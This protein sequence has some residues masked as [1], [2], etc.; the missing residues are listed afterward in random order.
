MECL[1][2]KTSRFLDR[3]SLLRRVAP[4]QSVHLDLGTGDGRYVLDRARRDPGSFVIGIDACRENLRR[5]SRRAP[6]NT[7]FIIANLLSPP[8]EPAGIASHISINFPWG[9]LLS[10]LLQADPNLLG[11]LA[12]MCAPGAEVECY[13]NAGA[14]A[15]A[16]YDPATGAERVRRALNTAGFEVKQTHPMDAAGL[17]GVPSSWGKRL[18]YG[19]DPRAV[20]LT[21]DRSERRLDWNL[22][23]L[24]LSF[25]LAVAADVGHA[26]GADQRSHDHNHARSS[27]GDAR[28]DV[29]ERNCQC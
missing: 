24:D 23:L 2:G 27:K 22:G 8:L 3:D 21:G 20:Y 19:R 10:G 15:E 28:I 26:G 16:G 29:E 7:L 9:S 6:D 5:A 17:R 14:L 1:R 11:G 12:A 25:A 13:L 4:Y 18:A